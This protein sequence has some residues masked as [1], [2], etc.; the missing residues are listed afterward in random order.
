M[1]SAALNHTE[2]LESIKIETGYTNIRN[3]E[4]K[5]K[6]LATDAEKKISYNTALVTKKIDYENDGV[7]FNGKDIWLPTDCWEFTNIYDGDSE[8]N[9]KDYWITG[10]YIYFRKGKEPVKPLVIYEALTFDG[11]GWPL[12]SR[13]HK[14]AITAY[15]VWKL[16][17][18]RAFQ[19][20]NRSDRALVKDFE[21]DW[22]DARD[23][24]IGND[25]TPGNDQEWASLMSIWNGSM[26]QLRRMD[27]CII[28]ESEYALQAKAECVL[29][30]SQKMINV[31]TW[32]YPDTLSNINAAPS[33]SQ[34]FLDT[35]TKDNLKTFLDGKTVAYN[36]IG[37][38]GFAIQG[39]TEDEY[40]IYDILNRRVDNVVFNKYYNAS[41]KLQVY[42]SIEFYSHSNIF[43][44][45]K[46]K[47]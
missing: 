21:Q 18:P 44:R 10:N 26:L 30:K 20:G 24:A 8:M 42:I 40:E 17:T 32:Q 25:V 23:A 7:N 22:N 45:L 6:I 47:V 27:N 1:I 15:V 14:D 16:F 13:N 46:E 19:S 43:F 9:T 28:K 2:L 39:V 31:Y 4:E 29:R 12:M 35:T 37:R 33:I 3:L 41:L 38:I 11:F 34:V 36:N 5:I